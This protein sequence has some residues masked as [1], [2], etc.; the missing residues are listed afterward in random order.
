MKTNYKIIGN[1]CGNCQFVQD[2]YSSLL[3]TNSLKCGHCDNVKYDKNL[4]HYYMK[5]V[6]ENGICDR[7]VKPYTIKEEEFY[8]IYDKTKEK[9]ARNNGK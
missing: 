5:E 9:L 6:E 2:S 4:K 8:K 7:F 3:L 1:C